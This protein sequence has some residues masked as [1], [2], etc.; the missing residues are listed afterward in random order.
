LLKSVLNTIGAI[1]FAGARLAVAPSAVDSGFIAVHDGVVARGARLAIRTSTVGDAVGVVLEFQSVQ[2]A[3]SAQLRARWATVATAVNANLPRV[4]VQNAV[5]VN[6]ARCTA[7][8]TIH[9]LLSKERVIFTVLTRVAGI[10]NGS[11][12][13]HQFLP[14]VQDFIVTV[15][16]NEIVVIQAT[17]QRKAR[18]GSHKKDRQG[19]NQR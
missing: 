16:A 7:A 12:A 6:V 5:G 17:C 8:A 3:V 10:T 18:Q 13:I 11:P 2:K 15:F 19:A 9:P 4:L 14:V 1:A